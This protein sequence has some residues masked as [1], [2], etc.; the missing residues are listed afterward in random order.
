MSHSL[1]P[2]PAADVEL[3]ALFPRLGDPDAT[4]RRLAL[5][6]LADLENEDHVPWLAAALDD[7]DAA[8]RAE[9]AGR[10][11]YREDPVSLAA[12]LNAL[13]DSDQAVRDAAA[14]SLGEIREPESG[15]W[16][17]PAL[18]SPEPFARA[19]V[20]R[21]LRELRLP[22]SF[23][24]A[25][26]ATQDTFAQVRLEAVGVLGWLKRVE[27]LP[28]LIHLA[29]SDPDPEVRRAAV[30]AIGLA[31]DA[32]DAN[33]L[34][35]LLQALQDPAWQVREEAATTLGKLKL[36]GSLNAL[37]DALEDSYWQVR[38]RVTRALGRLGD[39]RAVPAIT[40]SAL[41]HGS[42][43]LRKEA[44][45]A[46]GEIADPSAVPALEQAAQ[47]GDPEVRKAARLALG[48]IGQRA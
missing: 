48:M 12:L 6:E 5:I 39:A 32:S 45:I 4:V 13:T 16:L 25:L 3:S 46:L 22:A 24:P 11:S 10:L 33:V 14:F 8:V 7:A 35:S 19:A 18:A 41:V 9:A 20:L 40:G 34:A 42:A 38:Q 47:D 37:L 30:G 44:A 15:Q 21:A 1:P 17:L 27:A 28:A 43:N 29:N 2:P 23:L 31:T 26:K 36:A